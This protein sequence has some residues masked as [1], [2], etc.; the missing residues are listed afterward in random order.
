MLVFVV[1]LS[2][3]S[4]SSALA[5]WHEWSQSIRNQAIVNRAAQDD[6]DYVGEN[7]KEWARTVV[8][9]ASGNLADIPSTH[10]DLYY[11][12]SD[13]NVVGRSG[14]IEYAQ[15]GEI[16][17]MKLKSDIEHTAIV[18]GTSPW[19]VTFV[20]SNWCTPECLTVDMRYVSYTDFY[21]DEVDSFTIYYVK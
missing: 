16:V 15:P 8:K 3:S 5:G 19:G 1:S 14:L 13:S 6:G 12:Y 7:C 21:D 10:P 9:G 2:L 4:A 20:E 11:W 17:Q 18:V